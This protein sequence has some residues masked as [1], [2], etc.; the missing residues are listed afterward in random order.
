MANQSIEGFIDNWAY[1]KTELSWLDR[2]LMM[3][4]AR[5]RQDKKS[6]DRLA[7]SPADQASS[8]WWKGVISVDGKVA[9]DEHRPGAIL[10]GS[11]ANTANKSSQ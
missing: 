2:M 9:Y 6:V 11:G 1:L 4:L 7:Q 10:P 5:Y 3:A 8:H